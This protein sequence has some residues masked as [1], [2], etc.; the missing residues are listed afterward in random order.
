MT[1]LKTI[2]FVFVLFVFL[3]V[4]CKNDPIIPVDISFHKWKV[5]SIAKPTNT[6]VA[7]GD[8]IFQFYDTENYS[9]AINNCFDH[10]ECVG[11]YRIPG[12]G[13]TLVI[14]GC[15]CTKVCCR[16]DF[17]KELIEATRQVT[18]YSVNQDTLILSGKFNIKLIKEDEVPDDIRFIVHHWEVLNITPPGQNQP[19][20]PPMSY[21]FR[22]NSKK[23]LYFG[24]EVNCVGGLFEIPKEGKITI[25]WY[26][27]TKVCC[28]SKYSMTLEEI[29]QSLTNYEIKS[30]TLTLIG[31]GQIKLKQL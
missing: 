3:L 11:Q 10:N 5:H 4:S 6:A 22:F 2:A 15:D 1:R 25:E 13:K 20:L 31:S 8:Y 17:A 9:L 23:E 21:V 26:G 24:L 29:V 7:D 12:D 18:N 30:D 28:D 19:L 27:G 16:S 14:E